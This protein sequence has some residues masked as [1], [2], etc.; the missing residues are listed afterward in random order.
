MPGAIGDAL[1][2]QRIVH[3]AGTLFGA[4]GFFL[5]AGELRTFV[6]QADYAPVHIKVFTRVAD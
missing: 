6:A 3:I 5:Q 1:H 2:Q 4:G